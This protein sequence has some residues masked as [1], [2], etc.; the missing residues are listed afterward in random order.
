M[1]CATR[2]T[3]YLGVLLPYFILEFMVYRVT[4]LWSDIATGGLHQKRPPRLE[5]S[6]DNPM[7]ILFISLW[8]REVNPLLWRILGLLAPLFESRTDGRYFDLILDYILCERQVDWLIRFTNINNR[9]IPTIQVVCNENFNIPR[10]IENWILFIFHISRDRFYR[11]FLFY[12]FFPL[13]PIDRK[14]QIEAPRYNSNSKSSPRHSLHNDTLQQTSSRNKN[15]G[16][17]SFQSFFSAT[18][19]QPR[20]KKANKNVLAFRRSH[21]NVSVV[22]RRKVGGGRRREECCVQVALI[23]RVTMRDCCLLLCILM[24]H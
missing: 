5:G 9:I 8:L 13:P 24:E 14:K 12:Y 4:G 20:Q 22:S 2:R 18:S 23:S 1:L 6:L 11:N 16:K 3:S 19:S 17:K 10:N 21:G 7:H 15:T